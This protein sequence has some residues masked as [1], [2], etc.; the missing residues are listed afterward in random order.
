MTEVTLHGTAL[1]FGKRGVLLRGSPGAGKSS[2]ALQLIDQPGSGLG[3]TPLRARLIA[4]DQVILHRAGR[5]IMMRPPPSLAGLLEIRG[6]GIAVTSFSKNVA[7]AMVIDLKP[8]SGIARMPEDDELVEE[9]LGV[10]VRR[11]AF[12]RADQAICAKLR[13]ALTAKVATGRTEA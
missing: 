12:D 6:I 1:A 11:L 2:L 3:R 7:L 4:D 9:I 5:K 10:P 8:Q 13:A